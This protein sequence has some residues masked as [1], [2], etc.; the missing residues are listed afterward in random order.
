MNNLEGENTGNKQ[1]SKNTDLDLKDLTSNEKKQLQSGEMTE[2]DILRTRDDLRSEAQDL[3]NQ[4]LTK[5]LTTKRNV[6]DFSEFTE[7]LEKIRSTHSPDKLKKLIEE[8]KNIEDG[9]KKEVEDKIE[10]AADHP[11]I[12]GLR[13]KYYQLLEENKRY[14]GEK[15]MDKYRDWFNKRRRSVFNLQNIINNFNSEKNTSEYG[16]PEAKKTYKKLDRFFAKYTKKSPEDNPY[17]AQE[18]VANRKIFLKNLEDMDQQLTRQKGL[19]FYSQEVIDDIM[20]SML[21]AKSPE[22]QEKI[23]GMAKEVGKEESRSFVLLRSTFEVNNKTYRKISR[24]SEES[25]LKYYKNTKLKD[26]LD[27]LKYWPNFI[28]AEN[29]LNRQLVGLYQDSPKELELALEGFEELNFMEKEDALKEHKKLIRENKDKESKDC[30]SLKLAIEGQIYKAEKDGILSE[31]TQ[32]TL[33]S[34]FRDERNLRDPK[35]PQTK[36]SEILRKYLEKLKNPKLEKDTSLTGDLPVPKEIRNEL[37]QL[38]E[39]RAQH[40]KFKTLRDKLKKVENYPEEKLK[41][42]ERKFIEGTFAEK[43]EAIKEFEKEVSKFAKTEKEKIGTQDTE[44]V[45]VDEMEMDKLTEE[46]MKYLNKNQGAKAMQ[47]L[48]NYMSEH[49]DNPRLRFW[50][51][52]VGEYIHEFGQ[53]KA[54]KTNKKD[55]IKAEDSKL[56]QTVDSNFDQSINELKMEKKTKESNK[57]TT[58]EDSG[59]NQ[60]QQS[61]QSTNANTKNWKIEPKTPLDHELENKI[62]QATVERTVKQNNALSENEKVK[63]MRLARL[64]A[65][66]LM[67]EK[68]A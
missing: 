64:K 21:D 13:N 7:N 32:K 61:Q 26:R 4:L 10:L 38:E 59:N 15:E 54:P 40:D 42:L 68:A 19:D 18:G 60:D 65:K 55:I 20:Q 24:R 35:N 5:P 53:G 11:K 8:L 36:K 3:L 57:K 66:N 46:I 56:E 50:I 49:P 37:R 14:I 39:Y 44:T 17:L 29:E 51:K 12:I 48:L 43:E 41:D 22:D 6:L 52:T 63:A 16:L 33:I 67:A 23:I 47:E 62:V 25:I 34:F 31:K 58:P 2:Q 1:E 30:F 28:E 9:K 27:N 45:D